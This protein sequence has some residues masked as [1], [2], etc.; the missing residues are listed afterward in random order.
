MMEKSKSNKCELDFST[1]DID[2]VETSNLIIDFYRENMWV[3]FFYRANKFV[4]LSTRAVY[5]NLYS[6]AFVGK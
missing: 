1:F 4:R 2:I 6:L 3:E 5:L